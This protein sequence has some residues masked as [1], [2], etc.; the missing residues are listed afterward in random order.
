M[1]NFLNTIPFF[2]KMSDNNRKLRIALLHPSLDVKGGAEKQILNLAHEL[3]SLGHD[4]ILYV[5]RVD[6]KKSYSEL[7]NGLDIVECGGYGYNNIRKEI[8]YSFYFMKKM[9]DMIKPCDIISCHNFPTNY[10]AVHAKKRLKVPIVWMCNEPPFPPLYTR[11]KINHSLKSYI[12]R[13]VVLPFLIKNKTILKNIDKILVLDNMN[14]T[15]IKKTYKINSE[16]IW[17]G[18]D[19]PKTS[20]KDMNLDKRGK[21]K[22]INLFTISRL[23]KQ[24]RVGDLIELAAILKEKEI[25]FKIEIAGGGPIEK[26]LKE[27][28]K[29]KKVSENIKFLGRISDKEL[30][31]A[32]S[33]ADIVIFPPENQSWGLVPIEAAYFG[34]PTLI[35]DGCGVVEV[36]KDNI[37]ALIYKMGNIDDMF[38]KL[39]YLMGDKGRIIKIGDSARD[40]VL[41][42]FSWKKYALKMEK[43]FI[44]VIN[45]HKTKRFKL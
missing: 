10:A 14:K 26:E 24:R 16:I 39:S 4:V 9:A 3:N 22:E 27:K 37:N 31:E 41:K 2:Y 7:M 35:S 34:R 32:Y 19:Y 20:E 30:S 25:P 18:I 38:E 15:R 6:K 5:S 29:N 33:R 1:K 45:A 11:K 8:L 36:F 21:N 17:T 43:V 12:Y 28:A 42:T 13:L 44:D 23:D 40:L